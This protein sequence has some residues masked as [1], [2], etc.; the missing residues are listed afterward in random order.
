[1]R[2]CETECFGRALLTH[3]CISWNDHAEAHFNAPDTVILLL[4]VAGKVDHS[5]QSEAMA[6]V[7][8]FAPHKQE[9]RDHLAE[10]LHSPIFK[11]SPRSQHLLSYVVEKALDG[12]FDLLKERLIGTVLFGRSPG[13]DTG[14][15][16]IVRVSAS[17][18]RKRL[19]QFYGSG[20][21]QSPLRI[22]LPPGSYIPSFCTVESTPLEP[23]PAAPIAEPLP[24]DPAT[25]SFAS[26]PQQKRTKTRHVVAAAVLVMAVV[27][28]GLWMLR[29]SAGSQSLPWSALF[30][31][32]GG[33]TQ[34][35]LSDTNISALQFLLGVRIPL[36]DYANRKYMPELDHPLSVEMQ[37][38]CKGLTGIDY[39]AATATVDAMMVLRAAQIAGPYASRIKT[40]PTRSMQLRDFEGDDNYILLGSLSSNP[41]GAL[42][43]GHLDFAFDY[44][45]TYGGEFLRNNHPRPGELP[46]YVPT[47]LGGATGRTFGIIAF[48]RNPN[49]N[50]HVLLVAGTT[51]E[52]T[53]AGVKLV[54]DR[55]AFS[56]V[57]Q[58]NGIDASGPPRHFELLLSVDEMA[59]APAESQIVA[60]HVLT[61]RATAN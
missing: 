60:F 51:A 27:A 25:V 38:V 48:I 46:R 26:A 18:L 11:A 29:P 21:A 52:A 6:R 45:K 59:G 40:R 41:W 56:S 28:F 34:I 30:S 32:T 23:L 10:I 24:K 50:G 47:A 7:L 49:H 2:I 53:E 33:Q 14:E 35:I 12:E 4:A 8:A 61:D 31:R 13:Y 37:R 19:L 54:T 3:G 16:A 58:R 44:D 17:D 36:S 1:M 55:A 57:L 39:T 9:V 42:F 43:A 20:H 15:D 5:T 22:D